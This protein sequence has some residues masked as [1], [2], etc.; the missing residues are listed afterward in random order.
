[1]DYLIKRGLKLG[2]PVTFGADCMIDPFCWLISIGNKVAIASKVQIIT[3]DAST[4]LF[5]GYDKIGKVVIGN[6]V[7]VGQG[8]IILPNVKIG[9]RVI[10]G[11]G[12][13][14]ADDI[15][16]NSVAYG[17]PA[18]VRC[19]LDEFV[20]RNRSLMGQRPKYDASYSLGANPSQEK[21]DQMLRDLDNGIAYIE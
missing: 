16:S 5:L 9:D 2:S 12:S 13:V 7:F 4:K 21:K 18:K 20:D 1:M 15:P 19:T 6:N 8:S 17:N 11:A 10:I 14:V 3:H